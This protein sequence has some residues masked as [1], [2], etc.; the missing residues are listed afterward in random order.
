[1]NKNNI[2]EQ[3]SPETIYLHFLDLLDFPVK[4]ISSPFAE[5]EH[6]SFKLYENGTFKCFSS[7]KQGDVF[8]FVADLKGLDSKTQF[9]ERLS[10]L[11]LK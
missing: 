2:L 9:P 8:Q 6:P 1:M 11:N 7:G 3:V 10:L 4:N 5:D